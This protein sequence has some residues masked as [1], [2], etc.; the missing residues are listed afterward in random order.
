MIFKGITGLIIG[1]LRDKFYLI[2]E[3]RAW[4]A[5]CILL[6]MAMIDDE[7][8]AELEDK[9]TLLGMDVLV[10]VHDESELNRALKLRSRMIGINNRNLHTFETKLET[11]EQLAPM[12]PQDRLVVAESGLFTPKLTLFSTRSDA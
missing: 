4:G 9:A 8:A 12:I 5:D 3:A 11:T 1:C 6:I 10:E 2:L 7:L